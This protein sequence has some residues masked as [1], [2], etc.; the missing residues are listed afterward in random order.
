MK[1]LL[2]SPHPGFGGA[3]TANQNIAKSLVI[4]GHEVIYM[5]EYYPKNKEI[6]FT[7]DKYPI[8]QNGIKKQFQLYKY[9]ISL[10]PDAII[11]GI[12]IIGIYIWIAMIIL[13]I[14]GIKIGSIFHSL[15]L[16]NSYKGKMIDFLISCFTLTC[17][18][19]FFVSNYTLISWQKYWF[20]KRRKSSS[21]VIYN[22][23][24]NNKRNDK[25]E[26]DNFIKIGF[27]GRFSDEKQP[28][29]FGETAQLYKN[30]NNVKFIAFGDGP[31]LD[32]CK[33]KYADY[34]E[35]RGFN[36]NLDNIYNS[37]DILLLTSKFE[38]CPMIILEAALYGVPSIAPNVGGIPEIIQKGNNGE[39]YNNIDEIQSKIEVII[40]NYS[41]YSQTASNLIKS[42]T[43]E[44]K[45]EEWNTALN[46]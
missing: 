30:N 3:S 7:I 33:Q 16:S 39:L 24:E 12:P 20:I 9:L 19:L 26:R 8:H 29:I 34:V 4:T 25:K 22:V 15:S 38:N 1:I 32:E 17:S 35:F 41:H 43:I 37:I 6:A 5:D 10:K 21:Y 46:N 18:H 44:A 27:V 45:S 23:I 13:R 36:N 11:I 2:I 28:H 40:N 31:L 42:Y 14:K